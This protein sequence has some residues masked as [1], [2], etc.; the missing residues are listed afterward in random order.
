M[1]TEKIEKEKI[2][3][4]KIE[5][6]GTEYLEELELLEKEFK[7][8]T[9]DMKIKYGEIPVPEAAR[10]RILSGIHQAKA[11]KERI[12]S[13]QDIQRQAEASKQIKK[14]ASADKKQAENH[15]QQQEIMTGKEQKKDIRKGQNSMKRYGI[16]KKTAAA[17]A[18]VLVTVGTLANAES[19]N[20][21]CDGKSADY[22]RTG[23]GYDLPYL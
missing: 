22:W 9:L 11:E 6:E 3:K 4:E 12:P 20:S 2:E 10:D 1:R 7:Q 19:H 23:Q 15:R 14:E 18:A 16:F 21:K 8:R 17:A 5:K 13:F